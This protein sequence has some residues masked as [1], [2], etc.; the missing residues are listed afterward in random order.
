MLAFASYLTF[1]SKCLAADTKAWL[2]ERPWKTLHIFSF[3]V[4][5]L[6]NFVMKWA[7]SQLCLCVF[8]QCDWEQNSYPVFFESFTIPDEA[9]PILCK[10]VW[11]LLVNC[12]LAS[13]CDKHVLTWP[14]TIL[15]VGLFLSF[16][17]GLLNKSVHLAP[18]LPVPCPHHKRVSVAVLVQQWWKEPNIDIRTE[19]RSDCTFPPK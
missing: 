15:F 18:L 3:H 12:L 2:M 7:P 9:C 1:S 16:F 17:T 14:Q 11:S 6:E 13:K 4:V 5:Y 8:T 19:N 10:M